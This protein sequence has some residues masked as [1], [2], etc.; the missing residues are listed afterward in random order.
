MLDLHP[1][2]SICTQILWIIV[3][4]GF[5][6]KWL[7]RTVES[8]K[9]GETYNLPL[10]IAYSIIG[11]VLVISGF[12]LV[13]ATVSRLQSKIPSDSDPSEIERAPHSHPAAL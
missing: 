1:K 6:E 8:W 12:A 9:A 10:G 2:M 5:L 7:P 4:M 3:G 11:A 13:N